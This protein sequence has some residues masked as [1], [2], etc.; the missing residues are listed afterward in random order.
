[1]S[2]LAALM[3][4]E[5]VEVA[6]E[7]HLLAGPA[8]RRAF[9]AGATVLL[10]V[11]GVGFL[12]AASHSA[13][14]SGLGAETA[15]VILGIALL[16]CAG[17]LHLFA[18]SRRPAPPPPAPPTPDPPAAAISG[19]DLGPLAAFVTAYVLARQLSRRSGR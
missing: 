7:A 19:G 4:R 16:A 8:F 11:V 12:L 18:R 6:R 10:A 17:A 2:S 9:A 15:G 5:V 1:M 13:L 3:A 14:A